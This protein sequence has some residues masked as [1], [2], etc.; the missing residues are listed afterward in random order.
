[1]RVVFM[2][3]PEFAVPPLKAL[4]EYHEVA[5]VVTQP[6]K[7]A[8]R[9]RKLT[10]PPVKVVA[11]AAG[12]PVLQPKS[13]RTAAFAETLRQT[14]AELA[15]VVAYGKILPRA[16][17]DAFPQG[18]INV[19]ASLLP[20]YRGAAPI[21]WAIIRGER[22]TGVT[23]M[24]LDEGMDTGPMLLARQIEIEED[25]TA[26]TLFQRLAPLGAEAL[27]AA[28]DGL[29]AGTLSGEA[30]EHERA[31][32]APML[33][34]DDG[35]IDWHQPAEAVANLIRGVDPWPGAVTYLADQR[36]KMFL[37]QVVE[38]SGVEPSGVDAGADAEGARDGASLGDGHAPG[39]VIEVNDSGVIVACGRGAV[40]VAALQAQGRRRM[41]AKA[42]ASGRS[43]AKGAVF[44]SKRDADEGASE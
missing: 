9:G 10:P 19:H 26:G 31:T 18:C 34:K 37:P 33:A 1:M 11:E 41:Q 6:D 3:S 23:I 24:Q 28:M 42:F 13:A 38:L 20:K 8:G 14:G 30:Q 36:I 15:V 29:A 40:A 22:H 32:Y 39:R 43:L 27:M 17:L 35:V 7:R 25:E 44:G 5:L 16:V 4:L 12:V 21:Q 2:G